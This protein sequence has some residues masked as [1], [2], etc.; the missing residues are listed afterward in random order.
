MIRSSFE[1]S[2]IGMRRIA[3]AM[4][5]AALLALPAVSLAQTAVRNLVT[6][7]VDNAIR[8]TLHGSTPPLVRLSQDHG[9]L[10]DSTPANRMLLVLKRSELQQ[11]QL[12]QALA[13]LQN[14]HTASYHH[15]LTPDTFAT[16]F[17][18][19]DA[20]ITAA[21]TWLTS[22]GFAINK[23][24]KGHTAIEFSGTVAQVRNAFGTQLHSYTAPDGRAFHANNTD[25]QIPAALAPVVAGVAAL[26]NIPAQAYS[27][28]VGQA[29]FDAKTHA[30]TPINSANWTYP[31]STG[32]VY[33]VTAPGD[34]ALQYDI[35]PLYTAGNKGDGEIIGIVSQAGVDNTMVANYRKLF[36]LSTTNLPTEIVD[37]FDPG[38]N[39][40][41]AGI[42]ANLDVDV[43][44]STA[45]N[46]SLYVYTGYD[47]L[48]SLGL[49]N[50][51]IRAVDDNRAD[52]IGMSYGICEPT[53]GLAGNLLFNQLW[54]QAAAQGQT[55]IVSSGDSGGAGCDN[56]QSSGLHGLSVN[57]ITSTPYNLSMGGT[58]FYYAAYGSSGL[59]ATVNSYWNKTASPSPSTSILKVIP[60]QPWNDAFGLNAGGPPTTGTIAAGSGGPSSC[61]SGVSAPPT[62]GS[63]VDSFISCAAGTPKPSWQSAPGVPTDGVRDIPDISLFAANG[64]NYS[65]YPICA[66]AGDCLASTVDPTTGAMQITGVG[67]TS[68]ST[69][70]MAGIM[71]LIDQSLKGRQGNI[72]YVLYSLANSTPAVFHDITVGSNNVNCTQGTANCALDKNG[73]YSYS[74]YAAGK[75]YDLASGLG[76]IDVNALL[77]NW[78]KA[79]FATTTTSLSASSMS[80]THG[81]PTILTSVV[82]STT[83][84]PTGVVSLVATSTASP[85]TGFG[86]MGL[87][88]G[89]AQST[90][91]SLPAG[92]Y[93][94]LAQYG[95]DA[96]YG[97]SI[98]DPVTMT[99]TP[100]NTSL[101]VSGLYYGVTSTGDTG[102]ILPISNNMTSLYGSFFFIDVKLFG[103]S[104]TAAAPGGLPSGIVTVLDNGKT[105]TTLPTSTSGLVELQTG[106][107]AV[108]THALTFAYSGDGSFNAATSTP[109]NIIITPGVPQIS[110]AYSVPAGMPIGAILNVPVEVSSSAGQLP[111]TGSLTITFGS[112]TRTISNLQQSSFG[113]LSSIGYG[114]VTFDTSTAGTFTLDASYSGDSNLAPVAHAYN[115]TSVTILKSALT[116]TITTLTMSASTIGPNQTINAIVKVT[117]GAT[118][119]T[120]YLALFQNSNFQTILVPLDATGSAVIPV[121][122]TA[123]L[124]NGNVQFL[125]SYGGDSYNS[126]SIS[127][128][129][130]VA[131]NTGEFSLTVSQPAVSMSAGTT[132]TSMV[133]VGAPY[134]LRLSG[135][136]ALSCAVS[137]PALACS[138]SSS[139][140]TLPTDGVSV[141]NSTL[142]ITSQAGTV[143]ALQPHPGLPLSILGGSGTLLALCMIVLPSAQRKKL[144]AILAIFLLAAAL[145]PT[146][147]CATTTTTTNQPPVNTASS[148]AGTYTA[149]VTSTSAGIT[150]TLLVKVVLK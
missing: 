117:G 64:A 70:L 34:L 53:L 149:T 79:T 113:G 106:S 40:D 59:A 78:S 15:W 127:N 140:L 51:A 63:S 81:S 47:T 135:T 30:A 92:T 32:G 88:N 57:G 33:L 65:F 95:G 98:S 84:T 67:G 104:S 144:P 16:R 133:A 131:A 134:G 4:M 68:A 44:G 128:V 108:G 20:D 77:T 28:V 24:S 13:D 11:A 137:S 35:N 10:P 29:R 146:A 69:P 96:T 37:G 132:A 55:V 86:T 82:S 100:E 21:N 115:P 23:L 1:V 126:A 136:V 94:L 121:K 71:A 141:A 75:G 74:N 43:A 91:T 120:G 19:T 27:H 22:Q 73:F 138:L 14:P 48:V 89:T 17:G 2:T 52:V 45:P 56:G 148:N 105:V 123:I 112:Q 12:D 85:Q 116:P 50:A 147:G 3:R 122:D 87:S 62:V 5:A 9:A 119:P 80:F 7:P 101:A 38:I 60:E 130:V 72:N 42:E 26:N 6:S 58:D 103:S 90:L 129:Q 49:F 145:W 25:P 125:A 107:L 36:G 93:Q 76:S 39:G 31:V 18:P 143:A 102:P 99:V 110:F 66:V 109:F 97:P 83:G 139:S 111:L 8:S 46:A 118:A 41:G 114:T 61:V 124:G 150:K 142:T 54:A